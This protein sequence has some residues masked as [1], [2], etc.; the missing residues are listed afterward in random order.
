MISIMRGMRKD[1]LLSDMGL[2]PASEIG[3]PADC[4]VAHRKIPTVSR[5]SRVIAEAITIDTFPAKPLL[6]PGHLPQRPV[7][8]ELLQ[9][10]DIILIEQTHI[11]DLI[12]EKSDTLQTD[13]KGKST[14]NLRVDT[15]V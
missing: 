14:V 1:Y 13:S 8:L 3:P 2:I 9:K 15:A 11:V 5:N 12:L 7:H 6:S 4:R 10:T